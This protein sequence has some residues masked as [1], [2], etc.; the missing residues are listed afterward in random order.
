MVRQGSR[1]PDDE[2]KCFK[3]FRWNPSQA[4]IQVTNLWSVYKWTNVRMNKRTNEQMN[5]WTNESV[6]DTPSSMKKRVMWYHR[7]WLYTL[8]T[9]LDF[10]ALTFIRNPNTFIL[11]KP[12][13]YRVALARVGCQFS[14]RGA[15]GSVRFTHWD[16]L[17]YVYEYGY[18]Y[19]WIG[20]WCNG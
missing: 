15:V 20:W 4:R 14:V 18:E 1:R 12:L 11:E 2:V 10:L 3:I 16:A 19:G 13:Q 8:Y 9:P 7:L 5:K 6:D 17:I